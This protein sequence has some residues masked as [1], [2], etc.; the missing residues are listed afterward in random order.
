MGDW[1][2]VS[3]RPGT[4]DYALYNL[5]QDRSEQTDLADREKERVALMAR[6]WEE[7]EAAFRR[8][9]GDTNH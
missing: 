6:R 8:T 7:L 9:A 3:K 5:R 2:L 4:N 1:K